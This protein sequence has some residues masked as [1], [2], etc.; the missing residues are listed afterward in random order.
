MTFTLHIYKIHSYNTSKYKAG[1]KLFDTKRSFYFKK[2]R[3]KTG[4]VSDFCTDFNTL[5]SPRPPRRGAAQQTQTVFLGG[6][7]SELLSFFWPRRLRRMA[8][9]AELRRCG[10][11]DMPSPWTPTFR[12]RP[13]LGFLTAGPELDSSNVLLKF[14]VGVLSASWAFVW[15]LGDTFK[16]F[17]S[18]PELVELEGERLTDKPLL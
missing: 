11:P 3:I 9:L 13:R 10:A 4:R 2:K 1:V 5:I 17:W 16:A 14:A 12:P 7:K 15:P 18:V 6:W 8:S